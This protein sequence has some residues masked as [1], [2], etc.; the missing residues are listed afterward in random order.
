MNKEKVLEKVVSKLKE[1]VMQSEEFLSGE[2][3]DLVNKKIDNLIQSIHDLIEHNG[4]DHDMKG[5]LY[6]LVN[7]LENLRE[8]YK[9]YTN[10]VARTTKDYDTYIH[11]LEILC[12]AYDTDESHESVA[13]K[14]VHQA[15]NA[16][17]NTQMPQTD[18]GLISEEKYEEIASRLK[19]KGIKMFNTASDSIIGVSKSSLTRFIRIGLQRGD[20]RKVG[21]DQYQL[22][23]TETENDNVDHSPIK[24][25]ALP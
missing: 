20:I 4:T 11:V 6:L 17:I 10:N 22:V 12:N 8:N 13:A 16:R 24:V 5:S 1:N 7:G 3:T 9:Y 2:A 21:K 19:E 25:S 15:P 18:R 14:I 23:D